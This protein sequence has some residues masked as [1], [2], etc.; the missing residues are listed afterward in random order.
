MRD[1]YSVIKKLLRSEKGALFTEKE[2]K[3]F[4]DVSIDSNKLEIKFAIQ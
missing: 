4:F 2:N 3:Y 1:P